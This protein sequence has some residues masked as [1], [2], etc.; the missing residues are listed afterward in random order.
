MLA[1]CKKRASTSALAQSADGQE[2]S[3]RKLD[4]CGLITR[5]EIQAIQG[6]P[7]TDTKSSESANDGLRMSQCYF[8]TAESNKSISL[9]VTQSEAAG[10]RS[11]RDFWNETFGAYRG[12]DKEKKESLEERSGEKRERESAPP[13]KVNGIGEEAYWTAS[14]FGGAL[15]VLKKDVFIRISVGGADNE[16][17]KLTKSK[18]LAAKALSRL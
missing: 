2:S 18:A 5:E 16:E 6:S 14:R 15:Y 7:M 1:G 3:P 13:K 4:V 17:T 10:K 8:A 11:A 12:G 9:A